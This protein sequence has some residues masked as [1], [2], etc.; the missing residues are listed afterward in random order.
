MDRAAFMPT[1]RALLQRLVIALLERREM[2]RLIGAVAWL[3][4]AISRL[5]GAISPKNR[6]ISTMNCA[7]SSLN[8]AKLPLMRPFLPLTSSSSSAR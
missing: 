5:I 8:G 4:G 6:A 1:L 3:N 2:S 7:V